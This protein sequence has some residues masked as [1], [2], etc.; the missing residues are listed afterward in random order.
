MTDGYLE[1]NWKA[2]GG[3]E[4]Y[5]NHVQD[6]IQGFPHVEVGKRV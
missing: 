4:G 2:K 3:L 1:R 6:V 5:A